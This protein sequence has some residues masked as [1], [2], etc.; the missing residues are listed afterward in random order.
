MV[1]YFH[2]IHHRVTYAFGD[3]VEYDI[4]PFS[5]ES[6]SFRLVFLVLKIHDSFS[7]SCSQV[8]DMQF[9]AIR[10]ATIWKICLSAF[11]DATLT[12][13]KT[14]NFNGLKHVIFSEMHLSVLIGIGQFRQR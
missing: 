2:A 7:F 8:D 10:R 14:F 9:V 13:H 3:V 11:D 4:E 12:D 6:K 1:L 5:F